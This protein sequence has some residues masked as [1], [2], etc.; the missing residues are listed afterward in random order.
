MAKIKLAKEGLE[1]EQPSAE[2]EAR[3]EAHVEN[4]KE[5]NPVKYATKKERGEFDKIP[6]SFR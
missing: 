2:R 3:W 6:D 5:K 1:P 4:Y